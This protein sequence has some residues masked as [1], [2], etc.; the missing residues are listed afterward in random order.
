MSFIKR[1]IAKIKYIFGSKS[2]KNKPAIS[3]TAAHKPKLEVNDDGSI[4]YFGTNDGEARPIDN[5]SINYRKKK[6][7]EANEV[8]T[9]NT[10][11]YETILTS[12]RS[13]SS[14]SSSYTGFYSDSSSSSCSGS[15]SGGGDAGGGGCD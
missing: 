13:S 14:S 5:E 15:D 6:N 10:C 3:T 12:Q 2:K 4:H 11:P 9:T 1:L 7:K 8:V